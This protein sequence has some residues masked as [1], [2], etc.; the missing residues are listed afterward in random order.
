MGGIAITIP[1]GNYSTEFG[2]IVTELVDTPVTGI[3]I[4]CNDNYIGTQYRLSCQ[5]AP[6]RTNQRNVRWEIVSGSEYAA[7]DAATGLLTIFESANNTI[8]T[9]RATSLSNSS[10]YDTK[11]LV[12]TY[13]RSAVTE[14]LIKS[15]GNLSNVDST[16]DQRATNPVIMVKKANTTEWV[17]ESAPPAIVTDKTEDQVLAMIE[18]GT[19]DDNTLYFCQ[20]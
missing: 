10:I 13:K 18:N 7:I 12:L 4:T 14:R 9:V 19:I 3:T 17:M 1:N 8:I 16:A 5:F 2:Q 20:E 6:L 11:E 15:L